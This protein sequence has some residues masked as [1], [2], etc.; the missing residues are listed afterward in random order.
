MLLPCKVYH[1]I[2]YFRKGV[3]CEA[4][5]AIADHSL[6]RMKNLGL[7]PNPQ[8]RN[9]PL[10]PFKKLPQPP[11]FF[12]GAPSPVGRNKRGVCFSAKRVRVRSN[13][14]LLKFSF[15]SLRFDQSDLPLTIATFPFSLQRVKK[16][17]R[18]EIIPRIFCI[19][20]ILIAL[21]ILLLLIKFPNFPRIFR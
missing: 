1:T 14:Q 7:C 19:F 17:K 20:C 9:S 12:E 6:K 21:Y 18:Y 5:S 3:L 11:H 13:C 8:G 4:A 10:T 15:S 16:H 2:L